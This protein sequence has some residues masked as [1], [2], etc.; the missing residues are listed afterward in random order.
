MEDSLEMG[1]QL[2]GNQ[3]VITGLSHQEALNRLER[4]GHNELKT[5][6]PRGVMKII[7][8]AIREPMVLLL[9]GLAEYFLHSLDEFCDVLISNAVI[10]KSAIAPHVQKFFPLKTVQKLR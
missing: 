10:R 3:E 8:G 1:N 5:D 2:I 9:I 7:L 6:G 4:F